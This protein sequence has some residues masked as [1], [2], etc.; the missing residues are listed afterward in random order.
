MTLLKAKIDTCVI[1]AG[2]QGTRLRALDPDRP[3]ALTP[4]LGEPI[5]SCQINLLVQ[6]GIKNFHLLLNYHAEQIINF[7]E[8]KYKNP[9]L[10]FT[11]YTENMPLGS[12]GGLVNIYQDLPS[13]FLFTYC[14]IYF[15]INL[16][17]LL[18]FHMCKNADFTLV[19]HPNDHPFD[20]DLIELDKTGRVVSLS[21]CP[22]SLDTFP[23]NVVNAAFYVV[24]RDLLKNF[25]HGV[26]RDFAKD[27]IPEML[28]RHKCYGY[29]T[30]ELLKDMGTPDRLDKLV[31]HYAGISPTKKKNV[32]FLDRDGTLNKITKGSYITSSDDLELID[33]AGE[34][35]RILRELG[36]LLV[37]IT[38]QP[39]LARGDVSYDELKLIHNRLDWQL[40]KQEA[41]LDYKFYCPHHPDR[42]YEGE[43]ANLKTDCECRK[44]G[45]GMLTEASMLFNID[46]EKS[47]M[48]G[49]SLSDVKAG[50]NFGLNTCI[51]TLTSTDCAADETAESLIE[52]AIARR[53][54]KSAN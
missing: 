22:H 16:D 8:K 34:G 37:L 46:L 52:F 13:L 32:I 27:M 43:V 29:L 25:E 20:S 17:K 30:H 35:C 54:L 45:I 15:D 41:Y 11:Y 47:W 4:I 53:N 21:S 38:N 51:L 42:G 48:V 40:A 26:K 9:Q 7:I 44:P 36:Y 28:K 10:T 18:N 1:A 39:V 3:K 6:S 33:G 14:D 50:K 31:K 5:L 12:G 49:D 19:C 24:N 2:G 23:G